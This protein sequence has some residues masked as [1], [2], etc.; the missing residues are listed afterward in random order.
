MT[1]SR[2]R[3]VVA[4]LAIGDGVIGAVA[5]ARHM[6]RWLSGPAPYEALMRPF[7][8]HLQ[9]TRGLAVLE[10]AAA[11]AYVLRLPTRH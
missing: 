2:I 5:P 7:A 4:L 11:T 3:A 6:A 1:S 8:R 9:L 10:A